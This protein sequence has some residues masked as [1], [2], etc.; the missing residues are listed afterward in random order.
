MT[1]YSGYY[2]IYKSS[3]NTIFQ[4][5]YK[6]TSK[7]GYVEGKK[8]CTLSVVYLTRLKDLTIFICDD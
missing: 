4:Y 6:M 2:M 8:E 3:C 7:P 1:P 5:G